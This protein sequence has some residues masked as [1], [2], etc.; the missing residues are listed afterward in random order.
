VRGKIIMTITH[1]KST[2]FAA[3]GRNFCAYFPCNFHESNYDRFG[4]WTT[5]LVMP[6][7]VS[8]WNVYEIM[9]LGREARA[10]LF[11]YPNAV[12]LLL[13]L[14]FLDFYQYTTSIIFAELAPVRHDIA[15]SGL[16]I[17]Y[18]FLSSSS[19]HIHVLWNSMSARL[20]KDEFG[21]IIVYD[22]RLSSGKS[23]VESWSDFK[24]QLS[25]E[26]DVEL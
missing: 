7:D 5:E 19:I 1:K 20:R 13:L 6:D 21:T 11:E 22:I 10:Q 3:L 12:L 23:V 18:E 25:R 16:P 14:D 9:D 2:L 15:P 26:D 17:F 24:I 4:V 8:P